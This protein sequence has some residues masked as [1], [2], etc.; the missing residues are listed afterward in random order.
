[1][2]EQP[3]AE[4][5]IGKQKGSWPTLAFRDEAHAAAWL[6]QDRSDRRAWQVRLTDPVELVLDEVQE[7][8]LVP[9]EG[10]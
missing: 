9:K 6:F 3:P 10:P 1:V 8:R 4:L 2:S 7:P 5:I